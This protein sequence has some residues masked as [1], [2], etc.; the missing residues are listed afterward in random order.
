MC[1]ASHLPLSH[2]LTLHCLM[3]VLMRCVGAH[4]IVTIAT[5]IHAC[6]MLQISLSVL[7]ART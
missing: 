6:V 1:H 4:D 2:D 5:T 3:L 7:H